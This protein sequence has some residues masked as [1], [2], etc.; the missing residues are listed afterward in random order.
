MNFSAHLRGFNLPDIPRY[1]DALGEDLGV[2]PEIPRQTLLPRKRFEIWR[3]YADFHVALSLHGRGL[4]YALHAEL[5]TIDAPAA[6]ILSRAYR[7]FKFNGTHSAA[8]ASLHPTE[9]RLRALCARNFADGS[10]RPAALSL[11][12]RPG[13][14]AEV[15]S[16][17]GV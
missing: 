7:V 11:S 10:R 6:S 4:D 3:A 12:E 8:P 14:M 5:G 9:R 1:T 13:V 17:A 16:G 15:L 2:A